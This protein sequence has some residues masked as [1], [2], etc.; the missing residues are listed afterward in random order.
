MMRVQFPRFAINSQP[1][2]GCT[3]DN[4]DIAIRRKSDT[5]CLLLENKRKNE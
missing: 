1:F 5:L 4:Y 3:A 2:T